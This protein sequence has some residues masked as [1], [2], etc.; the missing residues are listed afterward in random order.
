MEIGKLQHPNKVLLFVVLGVVFLAA[1]YT[2]QDSA[3]VS[4]HIE[5]LAW[6]DAKKLSDGD[7][8][9]RKGHDLISRLV[10]TQGN[11]AQF[12]HVGI[13][14]I[15]EGIVSV[16]H[17]LPEDVNTSSGVQVESLDSFVSIENA[18]DVAVY[19]ITGIDTKSRQKIRE[20]VL[21]QVGKPFDTS[22]L[23]ST[24]DS[25]YCTELVVKAYIAVGII[26]VTLINE[27]VIPPDHLRWSHRLERL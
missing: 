22:L 12:S 18:S 16:I 26:R 23:M 7:L 3:N 13:I 8:I 24:D 15:R 11:S 14:L 27:P 20:Y 2:N 19:R 21:K 9:F 6:I 25:M 10:L 5:S 1:T 17:S 4:T